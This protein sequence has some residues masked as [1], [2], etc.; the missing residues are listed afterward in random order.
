[1]SALMKKIK[2]KKVDKQTDEWR[3]EKRDRRVVNLIK[4]LRL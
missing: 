1:M 2:D 4:A 3:L